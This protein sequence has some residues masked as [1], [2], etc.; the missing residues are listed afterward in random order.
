[1]EL[2]FLPFPFYIKGELHFGTA[3]ILDKQSKTFRVTLLDDEIDIRFSI[4]DKILWEQVGE[5]VLPREFVQAV[6]DGIV[7]MVLRRCGID[8][9]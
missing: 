8:Y 3:E 4:G 1:M 6:G 9:M 7:S 5:A 2:T